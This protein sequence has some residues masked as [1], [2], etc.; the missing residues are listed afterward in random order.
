MPQIESRR[1]ADLAPYDRNARVHS[2]EQIEQLTA[3]IKE[4]G[5]TN[6]VLITP[7]GMIVAGHGR[8]EAAKAAGLEEVPTLTV[9]A[10]WSPEKIRVLISTES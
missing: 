7:E 3:A 6:P 4:F 1:I 10:D 2:A 9:G 8:V 5:F